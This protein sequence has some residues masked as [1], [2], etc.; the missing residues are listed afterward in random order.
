MLGK[1]EGSMSADG[2]TC[3]GMISH[4]YLTLDT[5]IPTASLST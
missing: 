3:S 4:H 2:Q 5:T 1:R